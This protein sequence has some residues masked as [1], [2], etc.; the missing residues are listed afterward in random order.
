ML[1]VGVINKVLRPSVRTNIGDWKLAPRIRLTKRDFRILSDVTEFDLLTTSQLMQLHFASLSRTQKRLRL[2]WMAGFVSRSHINF[3]KS[4]ELVYRIAR[5]GS[6]ALTGNGSESNGRS[7]STKPASMMFVEHTILRNEFRLRLMRSLAKATDTSLVFWKQGSDIAISVSL[8]TFGASPQLKRVPVVADGLFCLRHSGASQCFFVE[9]DRGTTS[10]I[11]VREKLAA[12]NKLVTTDKFLRRF[13][14]N[15]FRVL[16]VTTSRRRLDHLIAA[17][18][19]V[20]TRRGL[21]YYGLLGEV[22]S[23]NDSILAYTWNTHGGEGASRSLN[24]MIGY[25]VGSFSSDFWERI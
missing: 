11:R 3:R 24:D 13:G 15:H 23:K 18:R 4:D 22:L 1:R 2:L 5:K 10:V 9:I 14:T 19:Q 25:S 12:Y 21:L 8:V 7:R 6:Q 20:C 17:G 16:Y